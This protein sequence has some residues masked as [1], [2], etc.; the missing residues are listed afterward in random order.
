VSASFEGAHGYSFSEQCLVYGGCYRKEFLQQIVRRFIS[1]ANAPE[2]ATLQRALRERKKNL[3]KPRKRGRPRA[4]ESDRWIRLALNQAR[5]KYVLG[6]T[7][8]KIAKR[9]GMRVLDA[10]RKQSG[11]RKQIEW[12]LKRRLLKLAEW[13]L[14]KVPPT[15]GH[16]ATPLEV[17]YAW[18]NLSGALGFPP[19]ECKAIGRGLA[20]ADQRRMNFPIGNRKSPA[21]KEPRINSPDAPRL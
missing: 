5:Q 4:Y 8:K 3:R 13:L 12:I 10:N 16:L 18:A 20:D 6:W 7:W 19:D 21:N 17:S 2:L 14:P 9:A 1:D 11:N 15:P